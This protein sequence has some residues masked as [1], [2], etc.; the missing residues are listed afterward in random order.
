[1]SYDLRRTVSNLLTQ[2]DIDVDQICEEF[3]QFTDGCRVM[4]LLERNKDG[5]HNK[6]EHRTFKSAISYDKDGFRRNLKELLVLMATNDKPLRLYL[7]VNDR[8]LK[9]V[10]RYVKEALLDADYADEEQRET[11]HKKLLRSPKHFL[12]QTQNKNSNWF[13]I[14]VDNEEGRDVMGEALDELVRLE[15]DEL[16]RYPTKNGWH[17][18]VKPFNLSLWNGPGEVKKDSMLLLKY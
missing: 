5:G 11:T 8:N 10:I 2:I 18:V 13:L 9:K 3:D 1:M 14:D 12:M 16:K 6:E 17:F 15:V 7:S 4:I